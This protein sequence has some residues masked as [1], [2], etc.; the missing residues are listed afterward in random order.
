MDRATNRRPSDQAL[1]CG[2]STSETTCRT[3]AKFIVT[4]MCTCQKMADLDIQLCARHLSRG[5]AVALNGCPGH[6]G[7]EWRKPRVSVREY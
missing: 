1:P 7:I 4:G 5:I 6:V 3:R 2:F